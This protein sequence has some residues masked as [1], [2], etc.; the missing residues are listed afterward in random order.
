ML[1]AVQ[2]PL[3]AKDLLLECLG[4]DGE[5]IPTR[6]FLIELEKEELIFPDIIHVL[7]HG[8]IFDPPEGDIK[9]GEWKY[10]IEGTEPDGKQV[11]VIFS[12]KAINRACL[13]TVFS[14]RGG[15]N[16]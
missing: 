7:R 11:A 4:R 9:T 14:I 6:H 13:V 3:A 8:T 16:A 15:A 12:F 2:P 1:I 5:V 10:R